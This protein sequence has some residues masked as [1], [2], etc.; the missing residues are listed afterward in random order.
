MKKK[1]FV[2]IHSLISLDGRL[3][4]HYM[5]LPEET[6]AAP[7]FKGIGFSGRIY[8][9]NT[10]LCGSKTCELDYTYGNKPDLDENAAPVPEG[11]FIAEKNAEAYLIAL[12]RK[13]TLGWQQNFVPYAGVKQHVISVITEQVS[14]AYKDF[15]RRMGVSYI[16][17]GDKDLDFEMIV[18]KCA[19]LFDNIKD[20][21]VTGGGYVNWAFLRSGLVDEVSVVIVP[22]ADGSAKTPGLFTAGEGNFADIPV[23]LDLIETEVDKESGGV[24]L[25]YKVK[26][27][28]DYDEFDKEIG[29][30]P[31]DF[32]AEDNSGK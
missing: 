25:R 27:V 28:W 7:F 9:S 17:C 32:I 10:Q 16:I 8:N 18:E 31:K 26:K 4:G 11:D 13:G 2:F 19:T 24:W 22:G 12:D 29:F 23:A 30:A 15:L 3:Q 14:N 21:K 1:P 20:I 6:A 5:K